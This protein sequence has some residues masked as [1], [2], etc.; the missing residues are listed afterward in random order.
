DRALQAF[1]QVG[2]HQRLKA[3]LSIGLSELAASALDLRVVDLLVLPQT[4]GQD[5]ADRGV[6]RELQY[7]KLR[8]DVV[9]PHHVRPLGDWAMIRKRL[10]PLGE[11]P[12]VLRVVEGLD[13]LS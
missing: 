2:R 3:A 7:R 5:V 12:D 6:D 8:E 4:A 10:A 9:E 1:Q 13:V 11:L